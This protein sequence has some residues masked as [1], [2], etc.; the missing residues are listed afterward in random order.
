MKI[1][2]FINSLE[3]NGTSGRFPEVEKH[4]ESREAQL[5]MLKRQLWSGRQINSIF[6]CWPHCRSNL[7]TLY[8]LA[9]RLRQEQRTV[10][11]E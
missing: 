10:P 9:R 4:E 6:P 3:T 2:T 11:G 5:L 1:R 7:I 8:N